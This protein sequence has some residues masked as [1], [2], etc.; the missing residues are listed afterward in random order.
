M[1]WLN[2][3][4]LLYF[5]MVV[6]EGGVGRAAEKL[7]LSQPTISSQV[8]ALEA[9]LGERLFTRVGRRLVP[10]EVGQVVFR[11][12]DEIFTLGHEL[13]DT[14]KGRSTGRPVRLVVGVA[15]VVSKLIAYRLLAPALS[16]AEPVRMICREDRADKLLAALAVHELDLVVSDTPVPPT[17]HVKAY[18]HLLGE[19]GVTAFAAP[20][21]AR[22]LKRR[23]PASLAGT[24]FLLPGE[25]TVLRRQ[26]EDWFQETGIRPAI[27]GEFDDSALMKVFGE[28]GVGAFL[29]PS[30]L[31]DEIR[32]QYRVVPV[33]RIET[34]RERFYG[35]SFERRI[36]HPAIAA[37]VEHARGDL[38]APEHGGPRPARRR[39]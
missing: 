27:V 5:W 10:T 2:Y 23:F 28:N 17:V 32:R 6:R 8:R 7:R 3:H 20:A 4:H 25:G 15:D 21:L 36:K 38:F 29:A 14:V 13:L 34:I 26:L 16:L 12:A 33:G 37:I 35:I 1:E 19:C 39:A 18:S 22:R 31:D 30:A 24:P 11:Y 9:T